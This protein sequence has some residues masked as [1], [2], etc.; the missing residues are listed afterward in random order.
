MTDLVILGGS[1]SVPDII[2]MVRE[3]NRQAEQFHLVGVLD[4]DV[5]RHGSAISGVPIVGPLEAVADFSRAS[6]IVSVATYRRPTTRRDVVARVNLPRERY[7]TLVH[8]S[9]FVA[10]ESR[11][12]AGVLVFQSV[13]VA[14]NTTVGDHTLINPFC[15]VSHDV[16]VSDAATLGP[17][18]SMCSGSRLGAAAYL[19]ARSVVKDGVAIG[20]AAVVGIG[21]I[22][23][24]DVAPGRQVFGNPAR[25]RLGGGVRSAT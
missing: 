8:P 11:I 13:L 19:G 9:A 4:D 5:G 24:R 20:D 17:G 16:Q 1:R 10:P 18:V 6:F 22:V 15:L 23:T 2:W 7:V 14:S 12:G 3:I 25:V 21:S